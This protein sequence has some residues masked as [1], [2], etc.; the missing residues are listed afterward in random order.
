M[1]TQGSIED[2]ERA[3]YRGR[4]AMAMAAEP[5]GRKD[6]R[7]GFLLIPFLRKEGLSKQMFVYNRKKF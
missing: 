3:G 2:G 6:H 7:P 1:V 4:W 5:E